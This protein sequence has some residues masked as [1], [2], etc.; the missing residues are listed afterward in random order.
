MPKCSCRKEMDQVGFARDKDGNISVEMFICHNAECPN[1]K[2][3]KK[4]PPS[5]EENT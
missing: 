3:I 4:L 2:D 1:Y 5:E